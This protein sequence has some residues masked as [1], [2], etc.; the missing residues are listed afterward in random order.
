MGKFKV[1]DR[2]K[3][4]TDGYGRAT[5]GQLGTVAEIDFGRAGV[6]MDAPFAGHGKSRRRWNFYRPDGEIEL[7]PAFKVGDRVRVVDNT[8]R[9]GSKITQYEVG[10]E[11][12][13]ERTCGDGEGGTGY[14]FNGH[15]QYLRTHQ[16]EPA[17]AAP[18]KVGDAVVQDKSVECANDLV[19]HWNKHWRR[20]GEYAGHFYITDAGHDYA[21]YSAVPG[22]DGPSI[23]M[24]YL[25]LAPA[26]AL[27]IKAGKFY[28]TRDGRKVGPMEWRSYHGEYPWMGDLDRY[29]ELVT[30][31]ASK[32]AIVC[33]IENG[34][35]LPS[36]RP[37][38]H[39]SAAFAEREAARLAKKHK[40]SE[41]GVY[42]LVSTKREE[43]PAYA[44]E[45]QR[46]AAEGKRIEAIKAYRDAGGKRQ[47]F[48]SSEYGYRTGYEERFV[49]GLK[50]AKDAVEY[51]LATA[52]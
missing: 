43:K 33:L 45:W 32:P 21:S 25:K 49:I 52:A 50:E 46:L 19:E 48:V 26:T 6:E 24:K 30:P 4:V 37:H 27:T 16:I 39:S 13:I 44:H 5:P 15:N 51:W 41:F 12:V 18:F 23:P 34:Q 7:I 22:G 2:V 29:F 9:S 11:Y 28:K 3:V 42:T 20:A 1:G 14:L 8:T 35:P 38:V 36:V 47:T 31:S 17:P 10:V 40:G